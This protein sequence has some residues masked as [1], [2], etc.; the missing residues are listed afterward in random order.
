MKTTV[1]I[2]ALFALLILAGCGTISS[3]FPLPDSVETFTEQ[4]SADK[5]NFQ[6]ELSPAEVLGFYKVNLVNEGLT[7]RTLLTVQQESVISIVFDGHDSGKSIIVQATEL[8]S[9][10]TNVNIR[11]EEI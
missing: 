1:G 4:G 10:K 5:V 7:E 6:T 9:G 8:P 2:F 3:Q 11:L